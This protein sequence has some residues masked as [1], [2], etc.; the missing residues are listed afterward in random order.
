MEK[1]IVPADSKAIRHA[2]SQFPS[3]VAVLSAERDGI[4]H[5]LVVSSFMVGVSLAPT[6]VAVAVQKSSGTWTALSGA[7]SLGV[8]IFGRGQG[9]LTR[10]LAGKDRATRFEQVAV[11]T[12]E[13]GAIFIDGAALWLECSIYRVDDV[14]D[15]WLILLEVS[16][17]G[18]GEAEPLIWHRSRFRELAATGSIAVS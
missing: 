18:V 6:L 16:R 14:G 3:G 12:R 4:K 2:F 10:Q 15:H 5:A 13:N 17:L 7:T 8:S 1:K 9:D 11:E